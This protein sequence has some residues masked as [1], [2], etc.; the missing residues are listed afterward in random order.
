MSNE[1]NTKGGSNGHFNHISPTKVDVSS[2]DGDSSQTTPKRILG[3]TTP[4]IWLLFIG[5]RRLS[6]NKYNWI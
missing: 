1:H 6:M 3:Q 4:C 5:A 2:L